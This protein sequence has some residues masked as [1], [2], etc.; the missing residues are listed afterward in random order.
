[1]S[2]SVKESYLV[3]C[4]TMANN[5]KIAFKNVSSEQ[6]VLFANSVCLLTISVGQEMHEGELFNLTIDLINKSFESCII[7][8]DDS[9]Q[10]YT[11]ALN[12]DKS[13]NDYH[14]LAI[15]EGRN[16]LRRNKQFY[17]KLTIPYKILHW[18]QWL[19][20]D[21]FKQQKKMI[22]ESIKN[23]PIYKATFDKV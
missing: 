2:K 14:N 1:M 12:S 19:K 7:L 18:D 16:W 15:L 11:M 5:V 10:R 13:P 8:V 6:K 21:N 17:N 9:L 22:R 20:H 4:G 3:R 23:D